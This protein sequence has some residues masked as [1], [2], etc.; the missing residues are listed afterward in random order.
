[1]DEKWFP[2]HMMKAY[3]RM[4]ENIKIVDILLEVRDARIPMTGTNTSFQKVKGNKETVLILNKED[5]ADPFITEQWIKYFDRVDIKAFAINSHSRE[6]AGSFLKYLNILFENKRKDLLKRGRKDARLRVMVVGIPNVGKSSF[7]N[8]LSRKGRVK[9]GKKAG[10][11]RGEQWLK[12]SDGIQLLDTPGVLP[13]SRKDETYWKLVVTGSVDRDKVD[14]FHVMEQFYSQFPDK[15]LW[16][17]EKILSDFLF[18]KGK[19][20]NYVISGG[21]IDL[22]RT[23]GRFLKDLE[24]GKNGLKLTLE[25]PGDFNGE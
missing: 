7:I 14:I 25:L 6:S 4:K 19:E 21:K 9:V 10:L 16:E 23:A 24:T 5:L 22:N 18:K 12:I 17:G 2:G 3:R 8:L 1:M 11:T 15:K 13:F 20:Y